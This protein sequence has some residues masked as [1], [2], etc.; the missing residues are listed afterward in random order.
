MNPFC[1]DSNITFATSPFHLKTATV[2]GQITHDRYAALRP[3]GCAFYAAKTIQA[4]GG[5]VNLLS[6]AGQDFQFE[7]ELSG[8]NRIMEIGACTTEFAN[9]YP[10]AGP[11]IQYVR[12]QSPLLHPTLL[13]NQWRQAKLLIF[14]PVMGEMPSADWQTVRGNGHTSIFLQ[15][16]LKTA[17]SRERRGRR[18]VIPREES[19]DWRLLDSVN[20]V[21]LSK[22]DIELFASSAFLDRLIAT[23]PVVAVTDGEN[24]CRIYH[25]H[26]HLEVGVFPV[27]A[28]DP[29]GAGDTFAA[30]AAMALACGFSVE[31][32]GRLGAAAASLIVEGEGGARLNQLHFAWRRGPHIPVAPADSHSHSVAC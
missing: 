10:L 11:R 16:F 13:P 17:H 30:A 12:H 26:T 1:L 28:T 20:S 2:I 25:D 29:T 32:A 14:A 4:L 23:V 21:F 8:I 24:G 19:F 22:E 15:G 6:S 7:T 9:V 31:S 18:L 3:G 5:A 27:D